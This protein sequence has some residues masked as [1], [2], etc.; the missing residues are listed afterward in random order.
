M[1]GSGEEDSLLPPPPSCPREVRSDTGVKLA[2]LWGAG[3]G[4]HSGPACSRLSCWPLLFHELVAQ[5]APCSAFILK[6]GLKQLVQT[7]ELGGKL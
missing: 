3:R 1:K 6:S 2:L 4:Q 7:V 5:G